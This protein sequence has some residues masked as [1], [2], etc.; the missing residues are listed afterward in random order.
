MLVK[1]GIVRGA[2]PLTPTFLA[3][4][5]LAIAFGAVAVVRGE[6]LPV[7]AWWYAA[8]IGLCFVLGQLLTYLAFQLG[9]VSVATPV[10]GVKVLIVALL[11]AAITG[12][13]VSS[14]VWLGAVLAT[15]GVA[16][17]Q[18]TGLRQGAV[19]GRKI[20]M[21]IG[22]VFLAAILLSLFDIGLQHWGVQHRPSVFLPAMFVSALLLSIV[23][24]PWVDRPSQLVANGAMRWVVAGTLLMAIQAISMSWSLSGY[25]DAARINIV[26]SIR[27]L[28]GVLLAW[29]LARAVG[30]AEAQHAAALMLTRLA[31]ACLLTAAVVLAITA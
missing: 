22:L 28:W 1:R 30:G 11:M 29:G 2:S 24:L 15:I 8:A 12:E 16:L 13:F 26:Y 5:W 27:S 31:G 6:F 7:A 18:L 19:G 25:G 14:R 9:D 21:T 3:N 20:A 17:V 23:F 10:F 4:L